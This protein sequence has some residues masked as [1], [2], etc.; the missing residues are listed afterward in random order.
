MN[1]KQ[2]NSTLVGETGQMLCTR[3]YRHHLAEKNLMCPW[4]I[5][6]PLVEHCLEKGHE[7]DWSQVEVLA[8]E[9]SKFKRELLE[10]YFIKKVHKLLTNKKEYIPTFSNG[11]CNYVTHLKKKDLSKHAKQLFYL[12]KKGNEPFVS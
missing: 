8:I 6:Y 7:I 5:V 3:I 9:E 2:C 10:S 1:C 4:N 12:Y 11:S